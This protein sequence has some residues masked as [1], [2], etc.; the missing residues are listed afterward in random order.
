MRLLLLAL[1]P[2]P[3]FASISSVLPL[4]IV[5]S[6]VFSALQGSAYYI[7][8]GIGMFCLIVAYRQ[9]HD[10]GGIVQSLTGVVGISVLALTFASLLNIIPNV[11]AA[12]V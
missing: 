12:V 5:M 9:H 7:C 4:G 10:W 3:I 1:F 6:T 2:L 8:A 11:G